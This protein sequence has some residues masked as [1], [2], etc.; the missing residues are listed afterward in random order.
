VAAIPIFYLRYPPAW[1]HYSS[2]KNASCIYKKICQLQIAARQD[3][4]DL[5]K[6]L[7]LLSGVQIGRN[8]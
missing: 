2:F 8:I 5:L 3:V 1:K 6:F 4:H 7:R